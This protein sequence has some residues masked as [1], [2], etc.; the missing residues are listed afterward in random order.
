MIIGY[1]RVSSQQQN[2]QM[3]LDAL[4][5]Y[6]CEMVYKEKVSGMK[7]DRPELKKMI[8]YARKGDIIVVYKLDRLGRSTK[9]LLSLIEDFEQKGIEL[10]SIR[11]SIDTNSA[12]GKAMLRMLMVLPGGLG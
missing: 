7:D 6:G 12:I 3:Q 8:K 2:L 9:K 4:E 5:K 10:I 1:S 11:D